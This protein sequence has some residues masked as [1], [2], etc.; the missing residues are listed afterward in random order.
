[1]NVNQENRKDTNELIYKTEIDPETQNTNMITKGERGSGIN[2]ESG[3]N[4][5]TPLY[6]K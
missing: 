2:Q 1:M 6:I 3:T 4:L 5:Y